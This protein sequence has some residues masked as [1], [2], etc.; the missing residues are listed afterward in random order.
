MLLVK[1]VRLQ[2]SPQ[3]SLSI[4]NK[5]IADICLTSSCNYNCKYCLLGKWHR[6][7]KKNSESGNTYDI[8]GP[9]LD[10]NRLLNYIDKY[11]NG[12]TIQI[13]G[14]E[15]TIL[16]GIE[17]FIKELKRKNI[18]IN[19]NGSRFKEVCDFENVI[20]RTSYHKTQTTQNEF[21]ENV[22]T[23]KNVYINYVLH[24]ENIMNKTFFEDYKFLQS[25]EIPFDVSGFEGIYNGKSY[26]FFDPIYHDYIDYNVLSERFEMIVIK[27]NGKVYPC[28]GYLKDDEPI[29]DVYTASF[30][31]KP[32]SNSCGIPNGTSLCPTFISITNIKNVFFN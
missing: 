7:A 20:W 10:Y 2:K 8:N 14:G 27:P 26:R 21:I 15:P 30:D 17:L 6:N 19:T 23:K 18:I 9:V 16:P 28:H 4:M 32:C 24:P 1:R 5:K 3:L 25:L 12:Y 13:T 11:L 31:G 22:K 29:G